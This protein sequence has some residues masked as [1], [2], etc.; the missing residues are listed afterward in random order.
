[1]GFDD[2]VQFILYYLSLRAIQYHHSSHA[3]FSLFLSLSPFLFRRYFWQRCTSALIFMGISAQAQGT[4]Q[5]SL[6][7]PHKSEMP[8]EEYPH[9]DEVR[10]L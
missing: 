2:T 3:S 8:K 10:H 4:L 6:P 5:Y 7:L 1:M 9:F